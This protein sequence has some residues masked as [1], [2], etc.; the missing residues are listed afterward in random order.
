MKI[1]MFE[2]KTAAINYV[3]EKTGW[4]T[5]KSTRHVDQFLFRSDETNRCWVNV[6]GID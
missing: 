2:S 6:D 1:R 4:G 5:D 3:K